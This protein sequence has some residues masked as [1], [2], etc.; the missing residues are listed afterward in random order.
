MIGQSTNEIRGDYGS[1]RQWTLN[2]V[3]VLCGLFLVLAYEATMTYV[4][5]I[6]CGVS[7]DNGKSPLFA[8]LTIAIPIVRSALLVQ[9]KI[10]SPFRSIEDVK[11]CYIP[12]EDVC[13]PQGGAVEEYWNNAVATK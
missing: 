5:H 4:S 7:F 13:I 12:A 9:E 1:T 2:F 3:I 8:I 6:T 10:F 11:N